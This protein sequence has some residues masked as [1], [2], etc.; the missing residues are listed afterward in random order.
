MRP[1]RLCLI[2]IFFLLLIG[3]SPSSSMLA[4]QAIKGVYYLSAGASIYSE[5]T[6]PDLAI[7]MTGN[8]QDIYTSTEKVFNDLKIDI[9]HKEKDPEKQRAVI[10]GKTSKSDIKII[11]EALTEATTKE[12]FWTNK[13]KQF[14][15]LLMREIQK[16]ANKEVQLGL[17]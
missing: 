3:C 12:K 16:N 9:R 10:N 8:W 17:K 1:A 2:T 5:L 11:I 13:D 15:L 7:N 6:K 14:A 4:F